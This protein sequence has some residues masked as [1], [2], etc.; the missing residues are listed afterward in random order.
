MS[1]VAVPTARKRWVEAGPP[2]TESGPQGAP[3]RHAVNG[4]RPRQGVPFTPLCGEIVVLTDP[5]PGMPAPECRR[6]DWLWR[7]AEGI[8]QRDQHRHAR[9][10][11][12]L[13]CRPGE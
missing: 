12:D 2:P 8:Q 7:D 6:C 11:T 5:V 3:A 4:D 9:I 10:A 1:A 13:P